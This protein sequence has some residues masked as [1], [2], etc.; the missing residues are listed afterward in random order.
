MSPVHP[1]QHGRRVSQ[2]RQIQFTEGDDAMLD[3]RAFHV[4]YSGRR[5]TPLN[6]HTQAQCIQQ[7]ILSSF[8]PNVSFISNVYQRIQIQTACV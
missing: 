7:A 3:H 4:I 1:F 8:I 2:E 6:I 5:Q